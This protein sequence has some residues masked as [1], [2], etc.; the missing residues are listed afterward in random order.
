VRRCWRRIGI[1]LALAGGSV[2]LPACDAG[3]VWDIVWSSIGLASAIV[4][5]AS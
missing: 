2:I 5:V 1:V 4:D 3:A